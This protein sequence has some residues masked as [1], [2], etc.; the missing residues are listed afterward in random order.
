MARVDYS[1]AWV[2]LG[3]LIA[4]RPGWGSKALAEEMA[5]IA[6]ANR[7]GE[8]LWE[9]A[10]RIYEGELTLGLKP[11]EASSSEPGGKPSGLVASP[12]PIEAAANGR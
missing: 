9:Q 6:A 3:E 2:D 1:A 4:S 5:K 7:V 11:P 8:N 10:L 12:R